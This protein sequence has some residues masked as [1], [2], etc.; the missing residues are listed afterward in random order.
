MKNELSKMMC[1]DLYLSSLSKKEYKNIEPHL[2]KTEELNMPL[3]S[4]D[5]FA[6]SYLKEIKEGKKKGDVKKL[7][8]FAGK[9]N[10]RI[11]IAKILM[12]QDYE[13]LVLTDVS[14]KIIWVNKGFSEMT[15]YSANFAVN[16][17]P[18]FLSGPETSAEGRKRIAEKLST[19]KPFKEV[20]VN[21]KKNQDKYNCELNI[22][23]LY[24][25]EIMHYLA[26]E[27]QVG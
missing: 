12:E 6:Q 21:Y 4:W 5:I 23:P 15:G 2:E 8:H 22:I 14:Q 20:I 1:L 18:S 17:S 13:A 24:G 10:W 27:R 3:V 7:A 25:S 26:L 16:R 11:N 9:Y 19:G